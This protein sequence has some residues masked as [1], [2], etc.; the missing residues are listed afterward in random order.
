[1]GS[2]VVVIM[3]IRFNALIQFA[4]VLSRV[5]V[6]IFSFKGSPES[7]NPDVVKT[8]SASVHTYFNFL[9]FEI[10]NPGFTGKL[11]SLVRVHDVGL[12]MLSDSLLKYS[13]RVR[14]VKGV[15]NTPTNDLAAVNIN[16]GCQVQESAFHRYIRYIDTPHVVGMGNLKPSK[17]V[18]MNVFGKTQFA[19]VASGIN[20]HETHFP[21]EPSHSLW[22]N[23]NAQTDQEINHAV[24]SFERMLQVFF[25]HFLH[26]LNALLALRPLRNNNSFW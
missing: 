4:A 16:D 13:Q 7:L 23:Y 11:S 21:Q 8:T 9:L 5:K 20:S 10:I 24:N 17:L 22:T 1:M 12:T 18:G 14:S 6:N 2:F 15:G 26:D 25:V 3:D 19:Q